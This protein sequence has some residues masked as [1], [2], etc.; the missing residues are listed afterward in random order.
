MRVSILRTWWLGG[1]G[2]GWMRGAYVGRGDLGDVLVCVGIEDFSID[3]LP[4]GGQERRPWLLVV[5][6]E[7]VEGWF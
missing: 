6:L 3:H 2:W 4:S 1:V 5:G 7:S